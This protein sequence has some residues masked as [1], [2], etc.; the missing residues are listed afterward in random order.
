MIKVL[1]LDHPAYQ[2]LCGLK[3][4]G[5]RRSPTQYRDECVLAGVAAEVQLPGVTAWVAGG[6]GVIGPPIPG[7]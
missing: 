7:G 3:A 2:A 4:A 6:A 5:N 1:C